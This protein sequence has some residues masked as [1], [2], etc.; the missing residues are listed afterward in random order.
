MSFPPATPSQSRS[1]SWTSQTSQ[2]Q[3]AKSWNSSKPARQG[4]NNARTLRLWR[5]ITVLICL[6]AGI[7]SYVAVSSSSQSVTNIDQASKQMIRIEQS[8]ADMSTAQAILVTELI[9]DPVAP[10][11]E[12]LNRLGA[13]AWQLAQALE[14]RDRDQQQ[15]LNQAIESTPEYAVQLGVAREQL[16]TDPAAGVSAFSAADEILQTDIVKPLDEISG[17]TGQVVFEEKENNWVRGLLLVP[18]L[19]LIFASVDHARRT[20]RLLNVGLVIAIVAMGGTWYYVDQALTGTAHMV[21]E[22]RAGPQFKVQESGSAL[23]QAAAARNAQALVV[24]GAL[25]ANDGWKRVAIANDQLAYTAE[26]LQDE[27]LTKAV[28]DFTGAHKKLVDAVAQG[29]P[30]ASLAESSAAAQQ[31]EEVLNKVVRDSVEEMTRYSKQ[32]I[33]DNRIAEALGVLLPMFAAL[34]AGFGLSQPLRRYR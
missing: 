32:Q 3:A 12:Y 16:R 6:A 27:Q 13:G 10:S 33:S 34:A 31:L 11:E 28:D 1:S 8:K 30:K 29:D 20:R 19:L 21:D 4:G 5:A 7:G 24:L 14:M 23:S 2:S 25:P 17:S 18:I 26:R 15:F 9:K 22:S